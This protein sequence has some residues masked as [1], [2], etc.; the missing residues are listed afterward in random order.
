MRTD[1]GHRHETIVCTGESSLAQGG[2]GGPLETEQ[3]PTATNIKVSDT[4]YWLDNDFQFQ[5][6]RFSITCILVRNA[7]S[8]AL[9]GTY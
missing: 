2:I 9:P 8:Q 5:F 4:G 1:S 3:P 6:S 7:N